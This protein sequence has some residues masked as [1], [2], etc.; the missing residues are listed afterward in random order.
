MYSGQLH[1]NTMN[2]TSRYRNECIKKKQMVDSLNE[3]SF[4]KSDVSFCRKSFDGYWR[5]AY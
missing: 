4:A 1:T 3:S 5:I 2:R